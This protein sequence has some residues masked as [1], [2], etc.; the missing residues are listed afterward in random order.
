V[1][2]RLAEGS[3][4]V[5]DEGEDDEDVF[6]ADE[7]LDEPDVPFIVSS[8][9]CETVPPLETVEVGAVTGFLLRCRS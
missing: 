3:F 7:L 1:S 8:S 9:F 2:C 4:D 6:F 5:G